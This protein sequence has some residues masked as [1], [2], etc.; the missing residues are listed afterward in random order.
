MTPKQCIY[1]GDEEA[2]HCKALAHVRP[3]CPWWGRDSEGY[4]CQ[5]GGYVGRQGVLSNQKPT[6]VGPG[7]TL[8]RWLT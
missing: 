5:C 6:F 1:Y 2:C 8:L 4:V 7:V 3:N